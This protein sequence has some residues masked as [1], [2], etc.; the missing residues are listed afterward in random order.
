MYFNTNYIHLR[1]E[2]KTIFTSFFFTPLLLNWINRSDIHVVGIFT[3]KTKTIFTWGRVS[4][5][6]FTWGRRPKTIFT[7][8]FFTPTKLNKSTWY[9]LNGVRT[10]SSTQFFLRGF[11][12]VYI[13]IFTTK[14]NWRERKGSASRGSR[15]LPSI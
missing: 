8:F 7:C 15:V 10:K 9:M 1:P 5:T 13:S 14:K 6:I 3:Q 2:P 11:Y 12:Q 4:P